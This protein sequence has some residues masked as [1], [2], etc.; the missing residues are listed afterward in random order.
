MLNQ[1]EFYQLPT[2]FL[3]YWICCNKQEI[4]IPF[5]HI[6]AIPGLYDKNTI[7]IWF[8]IEMASGLR[9]NYSKSSIIPINVDE[10]RIRILARTFNCKIG[11][12]P[13][14]YLG[15]PLGTSQPKIQDCLPL[16]NRIQKRLSSIT[17]LLSLGGKLQMVNSV[18]SSLP[19]YYMCSIKLPIGVVKQID[20]FRWNYLWRGSDLNSNKPS[21]AWV[22]YSLSI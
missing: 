14:T 20:K 7:G 16:I 21:L 22:V 12:L 6:V 10:A 15:L 17:R 3:A 1:H 18:L 2:N 19:T 9:V 5:H 8:V 4:H 13:F 11:S